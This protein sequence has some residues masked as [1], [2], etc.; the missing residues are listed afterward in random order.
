MKFRAQEPN[1]GSP[2]HPGAT[3]PSNVRVFAVLP[4]YRR[5]L[6]FAEMLRKVLDQDRPPD[7]IVIV[8]NESNDET[9]AIS[10]RFRMTQPDRPWIYLRSPENLGS[11]GGW[12]YGM[13]AV[14]EHANDQDWI[15]T[16]DDDNPPEN[17]ELLRRMFDFAEIQRQADPHL[18]AVGVVGARFNWWTG[19]L[20]RVRD[21]ELSGPVSVDYVGN[22]HMAM[23][24]V[25]L[26]REI[27][28]FRGDL[29]FGHTEVE[30]GLR[31]RRAGYR[32]LAHGDVW[33]QRRIR[34][35]KIGIKRKPR[36]TCE[37]HWRK[38]YV[39]RNYIAMM[40][41]FGR[42][43]LALKRALIQVVVKPVATLLVSP[44]RAYY[45]WRLGLRAAWDAFRGKMGP[46]LNPV[47]D[48]LVMSWNQRVEK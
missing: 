10:Q 23:Y 14:L 38:Y 36:R 17:A 48:P 2:S 9:E 7:W 31:L 22:G 43:D 4:T 29:F 26:I 16:L 11:A 37:I 12:A 35:N 15:L 3:V 28:P 6:L 8:D 5:Q 40:L 24:S 13:E 42:L 34:K 44:R 39:T 47:S 25:R 20:V 46:T 1:L 30:F 45:G 19:N 41:Q 21:E 18:G 27:G 33:K 32:V